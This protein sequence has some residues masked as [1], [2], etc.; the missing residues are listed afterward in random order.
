MLGNLRETLTQYKKRLDAATAK[1]SSALIYLESQD[2]DGIHVYIG[3]NRWNGGE[4][5]TRLNTYV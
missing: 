3:K 2:E 4:L 1:V 5:Y